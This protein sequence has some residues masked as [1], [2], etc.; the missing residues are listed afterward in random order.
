[1]TSARALGLIQC[2]S[3]GSLAH[4]G[5][6]RCP[7]CG[8][9]VQSY[10][11]MSLQR[12]WAFWTAGIAAYIPGNMLPIM[13]TSTPQGDAPS[14]IIGGVAI[15]MHHGSYLIAAVIFF[16]SIVVPVSKFLVL[17]WLT[18]SIQL[19]SNQSAHTRQQAHEMIELIGSWSMVD[20]FVVAAL[21][22][23]IQLGAIM[24]VAP[25]PGVEFFALSVLLTM[26]AARSLDTRLIW[27]T[28]ND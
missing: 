6:T 7:V 4:E 26:L 5:D 3:C 12:V 22:A 25:G 17:A 13:I 24:R 16:A 19:R 18:L 1:M 21:A 23:L 28:A 20:V 8:D 2:R 9:K 10:S 27:A 11:T 14:T 15:L